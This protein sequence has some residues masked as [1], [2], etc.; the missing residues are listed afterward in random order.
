MFSLTNYEKEIRSGATK[1]SISNEEA[2]KQFV[3]NLNVMRPHFDIFPGDINFRALG[4]QW[5]SLTSDTRNSQKTNLLNIFSR[6][7]RSR[8]SHE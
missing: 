7:P 5:N 3:I 2:L 4:Q 6:T 8:I 1:A